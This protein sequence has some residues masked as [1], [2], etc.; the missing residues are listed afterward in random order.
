MQRERVIGPQTSDSDQRSNG[1]CVAYDCP[2]RGTWTSSTNGGP[3][4]CCVHDGIGAGQW[5]RTTETILQHETAFRLMGKLLNAAPGDPIPDVTIASLRDRGYGEVA[6]MA[7]DKVN[8][9]RKFGYALR[10]WLI[11]KCQPVHQP[12][13]TVVERMKS[14]GPARVG[15][16]V[17]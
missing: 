1:L 5:P 11:A 2:L 12:E 6:A 16:F 13:P 4:L 15:E 7:H 3:R 10:M 8:T 14:T 9:C 17:L